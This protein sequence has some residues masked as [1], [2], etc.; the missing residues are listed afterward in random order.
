M[1]AFDWCFITQSILICV[2]VLGLAVG[3]FIEPP[4]CHSEHGFSAELAS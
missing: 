1:K 4:G 2:Y 3:S